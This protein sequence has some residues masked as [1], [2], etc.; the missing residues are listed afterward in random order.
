MRCKKEKKS[1]QAAASSR[2]KEA[3][4]LKQAQKPTTQLGA[5]I[6][7]QTTCLVLGCGLAA[8]RN[9]TV[10]NKRAPP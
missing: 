2:N 10:P 9:V 8:D 5:L 7:T 1:K 3:E 4:R 6:C